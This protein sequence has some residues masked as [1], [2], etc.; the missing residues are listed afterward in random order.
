MLYLF[1]M[2]VVAGLL[3]TSSAQQ[4]IIVTSGT[5]G[6]TAISYNDVAKL[7]FVNEVM[8][9]VNSAGV[10]GQSFSL[11]TTSLITFGDVV[12]SVENPSNAD[13]IKLYPTMVKS[14]LYLQG[15]T[16]STTAS[17]YSISGSKIMQINVN[18][19]LENINVDH[20][21]SGVYILRVNDKSF[22][23]NKL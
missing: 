13:G 15:A 19:D 9:V 8:T 1:A 11:S 20:L 22:K 23:F 12:S 6:N 21:S 5:G 7:T 16:N 4:G 17:V 14:T 18:S 2:L 10:S 3:H